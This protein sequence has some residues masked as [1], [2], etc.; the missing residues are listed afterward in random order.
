VPVR[1]SRCLPSWSRS[2]A[3]SEALFVRVA[4]RW[5]AR[6][7]KILAGEPIVIVQHPRG[8]EKRLCLF[9]NQPKYRVDDFLAVHDG[10]GTRAPHAR[11]FS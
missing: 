5:D 10:H 4:N 9:D 6:T 1:Q 2:T 7:D 3:R 8:F 11:R